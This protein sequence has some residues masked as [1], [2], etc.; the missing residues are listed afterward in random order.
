MNIEAFLLCDCATDTFGKLNV[1]GAFDNIFSPQMPVVYPMCAVAARIR[2]EK[3]EDGSHPV[4][5]LIINQDGK[6]AGPKLDTNIVVKSRDDSGSAVIN[7]VL[8]IQGLKFDS[9]GKYRIDLAIDGQIKASLPFTVR[10]PPSQAPSEPGA[11]ATG[12]I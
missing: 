10:P 4:R 3:I 11:Q 12:H 2:F 6:P 5:I 8:N 7:L 1:L 9:Y